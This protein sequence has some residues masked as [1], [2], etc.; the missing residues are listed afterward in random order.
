MRGKRHPSASA[1]GSRALR[2]WLRARIEV[3]LGIVQSL[4]M[5]RS[6]VL[7]LTCVGDLVAV[8][9]L[10]SQHVLCT[11][12]VCSVLTVCALYSQCVHCTHNVCTYSVCSVLT[13]CALTVCALFLQRVL[14]THNVCSVLT[15]VLCT[16]S[17][18]NYSV[19]SVLTTCAL[20]SRR[21]L[22]THKCALYLQCVLCTHSV[23]TYSVCA[24]PTTCALNLQQRS[25]LAD[26]AR[27]RSKQAVCAQYLQQRSIPTGRAR[28]RSKQGYTAARLRR[29]V[30]Y[31]R[32]KA[33]LTEQAP[34][35]V[36]HSYILY[37]S[38]ACVMHA[39]ST[40][41]SSISPQVIAQPAFATSQ[42][43]CR[44]RP[45]HLCNPLGLARTV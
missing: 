19:C 37:A 14:C 15:S 3:Q 18:C 43:A 42:G 32:D 13:T 21:G 28:D 11:H 40:L 16:Y 22:C 8:C 45:T 29:T 20:Y 6:A 5:V 35:T 24:V 41:L 9:A 30:K 34:N 1:L 31:G 12:N 17:V 44:D 4:T 36:R 2:L 10:Y 39:P 26:R 33:T 38:A 7:S 25:T 23:C 27:D